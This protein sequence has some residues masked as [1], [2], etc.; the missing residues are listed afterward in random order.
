MNSTKEIQA[1][2]R[3]GVY[4]ISA[5]HRASRQSAIFID[6]LVRELDLSAADGH[7]LAYVSLYGPCSVGELLRV[8]G[9]R[10][11]TMSSM[12][13]RLE[14]RGYLRRT[15]NA[16]DKRSLLVELTAE[17]R[18]VADL[19]RSRVRG[20]DAAILE[21]VTESDLEGF[22]RVLSAVAHITGVEV[23]RAPRA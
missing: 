19:G 14:K 20:L 12:I 8:F 18:K 11:P 16:G 3:S 21:R 5:L 13:N 7:F 2:T 23:R 9:Y 1:A 22:Q 15:L 6:E 10:K 17:G 4:I